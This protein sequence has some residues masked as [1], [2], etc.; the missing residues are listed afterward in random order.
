MENL[1]NP[2]DSQI[3]KKEEAA[4]FDIL[5]GVEGLDDYLKET[6]GMDIMRYFNAP[7]GLEGEAV[8][9]QIKGAYFRTQYIKK[10]LATAKKVEDKKKEE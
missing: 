4:L 9:S 5:S 3:N 2:L 8:R 7:S 1:T 10:A 6:M